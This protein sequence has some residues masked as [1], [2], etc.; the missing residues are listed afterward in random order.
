MGAIAGG[1]VLG[2][3][4]WKLANPGL[5]DDSSTTSVLLIVAGLVA[6]L[7]VGIFFFWRRDS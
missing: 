1:C 5:D 4:I 3:G 6:E 2:L 7:V